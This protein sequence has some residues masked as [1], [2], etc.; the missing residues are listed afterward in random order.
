MTHV[1]FITKIGGL[2][3]FRFVVT[4]YLL[5][6]EVIKLRAIC[7]DFSSI[8]CIQEHRIEDYYDFM[9]NY[10]QKVFQRSMIQLYCRP[11]IDETTNFFKYHTL[12]RISMD[13]L[14]NNPQT[15]QAIKYLLLYQHQFAIS[16]LNINRFT[17]FSKNEV[18][19]EGLYI[20]NKQFK[21]PLTKFMSGIISNY[22]Y[23]I[24]HILNCYFSIIVCYKMKKYSVFVK[25]S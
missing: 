3:V 4:R 23:K 12:L 5:P 7:K 21:K 6:W 17:N 25:I 19:L 14:F 1:D 20:S 11:L 9:A 8:T 16:P 10:W 18:E 24:I 22:H 2:D 13:G 15:M